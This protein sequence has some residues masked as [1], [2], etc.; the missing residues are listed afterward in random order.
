MI[1][2]SLHL[3]Q[4]AVIDLGVLVGRPGDPS[5]RARGHHDDASARRLRSPRTAPRRRGSRRRS[6]S[7]RRDRGGRCPRRRTRPRPG[8]R[9]EAATERLI[10]SSAI[11][12]SSPMPRWAV[13]IASATPRPRSQRCSRIGDGAFPI[14]RRLEPGIDLRKRVDHHMGSRERDAVERLRDALREV[15][16]RRQVEPLELAARGRQ[17]QRQRGDGTLDVHSGS[18]QAS[19][20]HPGSREAAIRDP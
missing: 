9:F 10:S 7:P 16:R 17:M 14:G 13:S 20:G 19:R 2:G 3:R 12:Q 8:A 4:D 1:T 5:E 15:P 6:S 18:P 11:G